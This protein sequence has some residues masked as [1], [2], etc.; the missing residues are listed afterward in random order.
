MI[1]V[2]LRSLTLVE[3]KDGFDFAQP[4]PLT[5]KGTGTPYEMIQ[6]FGLMGRP[7]GPTDG[8][9][10]TGIVFMEGPQG[11]VLATTDPRYQA[12]TPDLGDGGAGLYATAEVGGSVQTPFAGFYGKGG[13]KTEGTFRI[14]VPTAAGTATVEI[15]A[16]SGD[17]TIQHAAS[18]GAAVIVK[19]DGVYLG[20]EAGTP[21]AKATPLETWAAAVVSAFTGLGASCPALAGVACTKANGT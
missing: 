7:R 3:R 4:Q 15:D 20:D 14:E 9:G 18:N 8:L 5:T 21:L 1:V 19:A 12:Q 10:A 13:D 2:D 11:F 6:P 16:T 17:V